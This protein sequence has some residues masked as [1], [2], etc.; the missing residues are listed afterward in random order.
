MIAGG[1]TESGYS[2]TSFVCICKI[3]DIYTIE[4]K[5]TLSAISTYNV[6]YTSY[7]SYFNTDCSQMIVYSENSMEMDKLTGEID[8]SE[9]IAIKYKNNYFYKQVAEQ[10]SAGG[11]DV[12]AGKTFIGWMGYPETGTLEVE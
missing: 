6:S 8:G 5:Q 12:R 10:L 11:G 9:I 1:Q 2:S 3:E 4:N 7:N